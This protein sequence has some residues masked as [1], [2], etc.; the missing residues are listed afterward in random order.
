[1]KIR[2]KCDFIDLVDTS[3]IARLEKR[4][5]IFANNGLTKF[6]NEAVLGFDLSVLD[7]I[8]R[9]HAQPSVLLYT[10]DTHRSRR[11][12]LPINNRVFW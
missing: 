9:F 6:T 7:S 11:I 10:N 12:V 1:M 2:G 3:A 5:I 8:V 4:V